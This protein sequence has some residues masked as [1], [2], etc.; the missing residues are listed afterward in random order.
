MLH[1]VLHSTFIQNPQS[2]LFICTNR[3][4]LEKQSPLSASAKATAS[5][6]MRFQGCLSNLFSDALSIVYGHHPFC[7]IMRERL[8]G[9]DLLKEDKQMHLNIE[10]WLISEIFSGKKG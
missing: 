3:W 9:Y 10:V 8:R 6:L 5:V 7:S 4:E 2:S 1:A